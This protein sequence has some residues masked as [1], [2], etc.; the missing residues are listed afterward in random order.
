MTKYY[1]NLSVIQ[2]NAVEKLMLAELRKLEIIAKKHLVQER[3]SYTPKVYKRTGLTDKSLKVSPVIRVGNYL[4]GSVY[5]DNDLVVRKS[6]FSNKEYNTIDLFNSG[7]TSSSLE[8]KLGKRIDRFTYFKGNNML[9]NILAEYNSV[10]HPSI[11]A[12]IINMERGI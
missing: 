4:H 3:N 1:F 6:M 12:K 7:W 5:F 11:R 2:Q 8:S 10:K 9:N